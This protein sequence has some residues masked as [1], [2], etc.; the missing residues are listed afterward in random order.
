MTPAVVF[1]CARNAVRSPMAEAF[2]RRR[3]GDGA[4]VASCG[5]E[6]AAWPDGFMISVMAEEGEDLSGFEC[7]DMAATADNPV[8]LV[9]CLSAE[10]DLPAS[11]FAEARGAAY[12]LWPV[13]DPAQL[14]GARDARLA[15]Y[16]A[17]RD[18]IKA[19]VMRWAGE[20]A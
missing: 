17:T 11:E 12:E 14:D 3:F 10:V 18:A 7:Q 15:G 8:E 9:V 5:V 16:R 19:R 6:P 4:R 1:V 2:W 13:D 20:S